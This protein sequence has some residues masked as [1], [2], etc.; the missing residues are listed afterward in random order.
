[1]KTNLIFRAWAAVMVAAATAMSFPTLGAEVSASSTS[2]SSALPESI[3]PGTPAAQVVKLVQSGMDASVIQTYITDCPSAFNMSADKIIALS[4]AGVPSDMINAMIAHDKNFLASL[5]QSAP[6][7]PAN[8]ESVL[9]TNEPAP[10][11]TTAAVAVSAPPEPVTAN[12]F[13]NVLNPYGAW[14]N[15]DGYGLCWRPTVVV[16]NSGWQPY[17]DRGHWVYTDCGWYWDSDYAWGITFHYGRWFNSPRYGWCW[18]PDT[19]WAPSWVTWRSSADYCGW[20]PLP[21]FSAY[22]PGVGFTYRGKN[23]SVSFGF[24]LASSCYTFVSAG[25]F[26][27]PQP[28]SYCVPHH[29]L[30]RIYGRTA[31]CNDYRWHNHRIV[32]NGVSVTIIGSASRHPIK[33]VSIGSLVNVDRPGWHRQILR[34]EEHS[35]RVE[36]HRFP[37]ARHYSVPNYRHETTIHTE[38][39]NRERAEHHDSYRNSSP[40]TN[41]REDRDDHGRN[42]SRLEHQQ[43]QRLVNVSPNNTTTTHTWQHMT[44]TD[45]QQ[46]NGSA[47]HSSI[48]RSQTESRA[49]VSSSEHRSAGWAY[50]GSARSNSRTPVINTTPAHLTKPT[51]TPNRIVRYSPAGVASHQR[52]PQV[53]EH[54]S[55]ASSTITVGQSHRSDPRQHITQF[56]PSRTAPVI[57]SA[58]ARSQNFNASQNNHESSR[59]WM[60]KD[61]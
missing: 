16:Y 25:H 40:A 47:T 30:A 58:P 60:A 57:S 33:A 50:T 22:Q 3:Q 41:H 12:D 55:Y 23:V 35:V 10:S 6:P 11:D 37:E 19:V 31:I 61:R 32:N 48:S 39:A 26:C 2:S 34:H 38:N 53:N 54:R 27:A 44:R 56:T 1:M 45:N 24:G 43:G 29:D 52:V 13:Y 20:A 15:V 59:R 5:P 4:D 17:C 36:N 28:R 42:S 8:A 49:V 46:N 21:P 9:S 51:I 14:I 7:E 18:W